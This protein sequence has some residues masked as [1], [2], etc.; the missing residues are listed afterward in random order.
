LITG[1]PH[2]RIR[3]S[4]ALAL[5]LLAMLPA[6]PA[7]AQG[8][9]TA[10]AS[11]GHARQSTRACAVHSR[12]VRPHTNK[13]RHAGHG[14]ARSHPLVRTPTSA[15]S[16]GAICEDTSAP[17]S[18]AQGSHS[19]TAERETACVDGSIPAPARAGE[20]APA[21]PASTEGDAGEGETTCEDAAGNPCEADEEGSGSPCEETSPTAPSGDGPGFICEG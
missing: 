19:C 4:A 21:C 15:G 18:A 1:L 11:R 16:M 7:I 20:P 2:L 10:C 13:R 6:L 14:T 17:L 5:S 3:L 9:K 12:K 8:H